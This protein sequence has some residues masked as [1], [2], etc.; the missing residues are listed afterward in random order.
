MKKRLLKF[1]LFC[2]KL[3]LVGFATLLLLEG[4]YRWY[5]FDFYAPE[6]TGLNDSNYLEEQSDQPTILVGGDSFTAD[7]IAYV[8]HLRD[9]LPNYRVVNAGVPGTGIIQ[10]QIYLPKRIRQF[11]PDIF[12][13]QIYLGNDLLDIRHPWNE[14]LSLLRNVY[15][16]VT[17]QFRFLSFLNFRFA[18]LRYRYYNDTNAQY[19]P[20]D[21]EAFSPEAYSPRQKLYFQAEPDLL[22]N[23]VNLEGQRLSDFERLLHGICKLHR[24][25]PETCQM[26]VVAI[27]HC[28]QVNAVYEK[29]M[30]LIGANT[31]RALSA[32]AIFTEVLKKELAKDSI[33]V[34]D[35]TNFLA[36]KD[37]MSNSLYYSNDPHLNG[38]GH[39]ILGQFILSALLEKQKI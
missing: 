33:S 25:L 14:D 13:Y 30:G 37:R 17:D 22:L 21:T 5:W 35:P 15:W 34:L 4:I 10:H 28:M 31:R 1:F 11:D 18:G 2:G 19:A 23:T 7:P 27:P 9:S 24:R 39:A 3:C 20:K 38:A 32:P 26:V 29:R 12:I 8:S 16:K 36:S 6:L